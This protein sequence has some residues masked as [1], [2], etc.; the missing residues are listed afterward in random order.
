MNKIESNTFNHVSDVVSQFPWAQAVS[1][2]KYWQETVFYFP[3]QGYTIA[4]VVMWLLA[5]SLWLEQRGTTEGKGR[6][7]SG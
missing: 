6:E 1:C 3:F 4:F 5:F 2:P 7:L